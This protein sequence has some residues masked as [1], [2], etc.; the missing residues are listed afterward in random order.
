MTEITPQDIEDYKKAGEIAKQI[1]TTLDNLPIVVGGPHVSAIPADSLE[2]FP[3]FD[4]CVIGEGEIPMFNLCQGI[5]DNS[6][7]FDIPGL[8]GRKNKKI[9]VNEPAPYINDLDVL[10]IPD[11]SLLNQQLYSHFHFRQ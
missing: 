10:P 11:R 7:I 4:Y 5:K 2:E 8:A 6:D 3:A 9:F 1:K